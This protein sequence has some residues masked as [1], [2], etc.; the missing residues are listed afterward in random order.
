[1]SILF[2]KLLNYQIKTELPDSSPDSSPNQTEPLQPE[3]K[4]EANPWFVQPVVQSTLTTVH[5]AVVQK[6]NTSGMGLNNIFSDFW[7]F[8]ND[9]TE[10]NCH[11]C[12]VKVWKPWKL[13]SVSFCSLDP[14]LCFE[15]HKKYKFMLLVHF[16]MVLRHVLISTVVGGG[17]VRYSWYL[18]C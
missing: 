6:N 8:V 11:F 16:S 17:R 13:Q 5:T 18:Y 4:E 10:L 7:K 15:I 1:M 12:L 14:P 2:I 3:A 9:E